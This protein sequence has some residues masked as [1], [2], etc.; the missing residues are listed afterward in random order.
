MD[1]CVLAKIVLLLAMVSVSFHVC[2]FGLSLSVI[3]ADIVFMAL[4]VIIT[5]L[6]C[7]H[8]IAKVIVVFA[9]IGTLT[10]I[11]MCFEK[12][13]LYQQNIEKP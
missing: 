10:Y 2:I 5:S 7:E 9:I 6:Y 4:L 11:Y 3:L 8:W 12:T 13:K 1:F